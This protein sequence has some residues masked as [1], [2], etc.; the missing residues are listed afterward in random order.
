M[1]PAHRATVT[2]SRDRVLAVVRR[3][4]SPLR[5]DAVQAR[6]GLSTNAVRFHLQSLVEQG[7]VRSA[8][9]P[10]HAGAGRPA[11]LYRALPEEA[12][13][14][15]SAYRV[16]AG[17]LARELTRS[18][19]PDAA[20]RAGLVWA[21]RRRVD[22]VG[23]VGGVGRVVRGERPT[24][25]DVATAMLEDTGFAPARGIEPNTIELRRCPYFDLAFEQP[26]VVCRAHLGMLA[27]V[28]DRAGVHT[29]VRI[30]PALNG[31]QP[32][33]VQLSAR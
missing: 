6:T 23:G 27:G 16:L 4:S 25:L 30:V 21:G 22:N 20:M 31:S 2:S 29:K 32:C 18:G 13:D 8:K 15:A 28:L 9:D 26:E 5:A 19:P 1:A 7:A 11:I 12:V 10:D 14:G 24:A 17:L 3:A 33:V